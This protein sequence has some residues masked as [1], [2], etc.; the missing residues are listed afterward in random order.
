MLAEDKRNI[1]IVVE[2][3]SFA[4]AVIGRRKIIIIFSYLVIDVEIKHI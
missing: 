1:E 4:H 3:G 2:K